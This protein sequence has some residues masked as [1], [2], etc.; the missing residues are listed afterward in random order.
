MPVHASAHYM[1][2]LKDI[3]M[4]STPPHPCEATNG[5]SKSA[6]QCV[7]LGVVLSTRVQSD[8]RARLRKNQRPHAGDKTVCLHP[9]E[10]FASFRK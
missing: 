10:R 8:A 4:L 9:T 6:Q 3:H 1:T 5:K 7:L 2:Y